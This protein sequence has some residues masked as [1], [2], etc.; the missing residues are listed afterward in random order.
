MVSIFSVARRLFNSTVLSMENL[1][2]NLVGFT[3]PSIRVK[4]LEQGSKFRC[5]CDLSN[6]NSATCSS[7]TLPRVTCYALFFVYL[8][9]LCICTNVFRTMPSLSALSS[10][11]P[12]PFSLFRATMI[13]GRTELYLRKASFL[14]IQC[15]FLCRKS[16]VTMVPLM[17]S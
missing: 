17:L 10:L 9:S 6:L 13:Q 3:V 12:H 4:G 7:L 2:L 11:S 5:Q 15:C 14:R 16:F 1:R 8:S